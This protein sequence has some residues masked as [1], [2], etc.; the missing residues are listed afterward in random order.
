VSPRN[1]ITA[2]NYYYT[3]DKDLDQA[4]EWINIYLA[5]GNNSAQF[6]NLHL[7]AQILAKMGD[8]KE[9]KKVA[10]QSIALAKKN[11]SGD[12]GYVKRNQDLIDSL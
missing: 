1:L 12:F 10:E 8:K 11:S 9:A 3:T 6:W 5:E 4:L 7:K 2:A